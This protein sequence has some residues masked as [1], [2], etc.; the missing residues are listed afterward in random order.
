VAPIVRTGDGDVCPLTATV[1]PHV[2]GMDTTVSYAEFVTLHS[3]KILLQKKSH[4]C[5][6]YDIQRILLILHIV[7]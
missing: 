1:M 7:S 3:D 6:L 5:W 2:D 4:E